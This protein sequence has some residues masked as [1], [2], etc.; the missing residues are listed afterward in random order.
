MNQSLA[1]LVYVLI[2][3]GGMGIPMS[4]D[5]KTKAGSLFWGAIALVC[6]AAGLYL[7]I[8]EGK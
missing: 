2:F 8:T 1:T 3:L 7:G 6:L 4:F 5:A